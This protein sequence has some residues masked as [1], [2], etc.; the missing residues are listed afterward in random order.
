MSKKYFVTVNSGSITYGPTQFEPGDGQSDEVSP[1]IV[2]NGLKAS[3][4]MSSSGAHSMTIRNT[5]VGPLKVPT[6]TLTF[7]DT[8][9]QSKSWE[10]KAIFRVYGKKSVSLKQA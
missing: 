2:F 9:D 4:K 7:I 6:I 8:E 5:E 3:I 1:V 10:Q